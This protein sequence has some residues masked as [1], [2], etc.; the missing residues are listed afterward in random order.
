ADPAVS[1]AP[2]KQCKSI[3]SRCWSEGQL[4]AGI[5]VENRASGYARC[6]ASGGEVD[7]IKIKWACREKV[8]CIPRT[9]SFVARKGV[10]LELLQTIADEDPDTKE[11][12]AKLMHEIV[13]AKVQAQI[14]AALEPVWEKVNA[15]DARFEKHEVRFST[16]ERILEKAGLLPAKKAAGPDEIGDIMNPSPAPPLPAPPAPPSPPEPVTTTTATAATSDRTAWGH[17]DTNI[18]FKAPFGRAANLI[19]GKLRMGTLI[20]MNEDYQLLAAG[21]IGVVHASNDEL[22]LDAS[23][24]YLAATLGVQRKFADGRIAIS[25]AALFDAVVRQDGPK[26]LGSED[27]TNVLEWCGGAELQG[28]VYA[29]KDVLFFNL[30]IAPQGCQ[31][32]VHKNEDGGKVSAATVAAF[33]LRLTLGLGVDL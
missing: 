5:C 10:L 6:K 32:T 4:E 29:V 7:T 17:F 22:K 21:D 18:L 19:G 23:F 24:A 14:D 1:K 31:T 20:R 33:R 28:K 26:L 12:I 16:I 3:K 2:G 15:H 11:E 9:A 25:A 8:A 27:S 13:A 30:G